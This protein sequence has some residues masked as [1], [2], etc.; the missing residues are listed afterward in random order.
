MR[1]V[2]DLWLT[3]VDESKRSTG[4][5]HLYRETARRHVVPRVGALLVREA[6]VP[7]MDRVVQGIAAE[8]GPSSAKLARTVLTGAL[9]LAVRHGA[10]A[11]NPMREASPVRVERREVR[12]PSSDDVRALRSDLAADER[13]VSVD[14]SALVDVLLGTGARIGEA[15]ALR[16]QDVD[17]EAGTAALTGTVVRVTVRSADSADTAGVSSLLRQDT[18]KGHRPR[19][20]LVPPFTLD[21]LRA[22]HER[23]LPGGEHGLVFPSAVGG[24]REVSTVERQWRAF[25]DRHPAWSSVTFHSFRRA[26]ATAVDRGAGLAVAA[27]VLGHSSEAITRQHY[28]ERNPLGPDVTEWLAPFGDATSQSA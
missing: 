20:L 14:L 7:R 9:G 24:L 10:L 21:V 28:V 17:L 4:T 13:A 19:A 25:R 18:T 15:L 3:T 22:Q 8:V 5:R 26:V 16:W 27:A 1:A 6:T 12:A 23:R 11:A 2:V